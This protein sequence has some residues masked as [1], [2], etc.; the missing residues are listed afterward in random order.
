MFYLMSIPGKRQVFG[1]TLGSAQQ[2]VNLKDLRT[3]VVPR[4]SLAEEGAIREQV[5]AMYGEIKVQA[6]SLKKIFLLKRGLMQ[7]LLT[8]NRRVTALLEQRQGG[9]DMSSC[10]RNGGHADVAP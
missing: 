10:S 5:D 7:D 6:R 3:V 4:P 8:G 2:V 9:H 1:S